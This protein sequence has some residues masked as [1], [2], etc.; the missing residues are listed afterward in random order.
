MQVKVFGACLCGEEVVVIRYGEPEWLTDYLEK[1]HQDC[2]VENGPF[3]PKITCVT[4]K[5]RRRS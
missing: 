5:K 1:H 2:V 3:F 4:L